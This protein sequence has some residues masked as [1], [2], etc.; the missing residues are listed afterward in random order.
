MLTLD[1]KPIKR[2]KEK[3][4]TWEVEINSIEEID[5]CTK[6]DSEKA[7][8]SNTSIKNP[9]YD[10]NE[11]EWRQA[12]RVMMHQHWDQLEMFDTFMLRGQ[13]ESF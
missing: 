10:Q 9:I 7:S 1:Q 3:K 13:D 2:N 8:L 12:P 6:C 11:H 4:M 5:Y